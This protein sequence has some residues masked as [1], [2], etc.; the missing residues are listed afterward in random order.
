MAKAVSLRMAIFMIVVMVLVLLFVFYVMFMQ[1]L[2]LLIKSGS[3]FGNNLILTRV[4]YVGKGHGSLNFFPFTFRVLHVESDLIG[5]NKKFVLPL[6]SVARC[7]FVFCVVASC[8]Y[9]ADCC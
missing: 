7:C 5:D 3:D 4:L 9:K 1:R 8:Q 6:E 2:P